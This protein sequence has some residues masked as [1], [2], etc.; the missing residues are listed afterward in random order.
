MCRIFF[1]IRGFVINAPLFCRSGF[2]ATF[3]RG[4]RGDRGDKSD[5]GDGQRVIFVT[6]VT[7]V[8]VRRVAAKPLLQDES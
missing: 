3:I 2:A 7:Q 8:T 6:S 1:L 5:L 4:D